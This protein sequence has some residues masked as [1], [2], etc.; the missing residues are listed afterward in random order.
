MPLGLG[1]VNAYLLRAKDG[2]VLV[3]TGAPNARARLQQS[4]EDLGCRP[5]GLKLIVITHG[6]FDHSGNA[7]QLRRAF[8]SPIAM[9][10]DDAP[11]AERGDMFV[12]RAPPNALLRALLPRL[13]GFGRSQRFTPDV[14]L[15]EGASLER[16]GLQAQ[17]V[18]IPGHS[19]GSIGILTAEGDF[20]CG[21]LYE[22][23]KRP[24]LNSLIDD[25]PA[26][27][28]SDTR[29]RNLGI[30]R[31]YPGHGDPFSPDSLAGTAI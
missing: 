18:G 16:Y 6:D 3:D 25:R 26:A 22:S 8:G 5:G 7:A 13:I 15:A 12:N 11:M 2:F 29:V 4:L 23:L 17:V 21:D 30:R 1:R 9:H 14:L 28:A 31:V 24:G 20:L 19:Q 27:L 10:A